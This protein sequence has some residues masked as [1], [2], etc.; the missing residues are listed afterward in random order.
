MS[1]AGARCRNPERSEGYGGDSSAYFSSLVRAV[2]TTV[3]KA[4]LVSSSLS[5]RPS[6]VGAGR[7]RYETLTGVVQ[8]GCDAVDRCSQGI[9]NAVRSAAGPL[10]SQ[11]LNL[12]QTHGIDIRIAEPDRAV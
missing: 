8:A 4:F 10:A 12:H 7:R 3:V 9:A 5:A 11:Q 1:E 6:P 2:W